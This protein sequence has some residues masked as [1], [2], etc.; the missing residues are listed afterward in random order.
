MPKAPVF[1]GKI[2]DDPMATKRYLR[3]CAI[4]RQKAS[5]VLPPEELAITLLAELKDDAF[6]ALEDYD[7]KAL[8]VPD[9]YDIY[10]NLINTHFGVRPITKVGYD[11][12]SYFRLRYDGKTSTQTFILD[13]AKRHRTLREIKVELPELVRV[14]FLF[15]QF[16]M[17]QLQKAQVLATAGGKYAWKAITE[18]LC[19]LY[20]TT[21]PVY[22]V[23][24]G[25]GYRPGGKGKG[26][27]WKVNETTWLDDVEASALPDQQI[28][29]TCYGD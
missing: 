1:D 28:E 2:K 21:F 19:A 11:L 29:F 16:G 15:I 6:D 7:L 22:R 27:R 18:A 8:S 5:R 24:T 9:G 13:A 3:K 4:W 12:D 17:T 20:P 26:R 14:Y 25:G 23:P 10:V